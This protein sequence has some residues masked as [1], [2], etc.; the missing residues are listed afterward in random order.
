MSDLSRK[1]T[2]VR[3]TRRELTPLVAVA[4]QGPGKGPR[5]ELQSGSLTIGS[6]KDC[7]LVLDDATVSRRHAVVELWPGEVVVK[8]LGSR[9]GTRY[10]G[11]RITS[12]R[13]PAG[14]SILVG[15][16][17]IVFERKGAERELSKSVQLGGLIGH[18]AAMRKTFRM[19]EK[20]APLDVTVLVLGETGAGKGAVA[21]TL[22]ELS[23][24]RERPFVVFDCASAHPNL[25]EATLFGHAKGAYTGA[26]RERRGVIEQAEGGTLLLDEVGELPLDVQPKLL[27]LLEARQYLPLGGREVCTANIRVVAA[28]NR[29]LAEQVKRGAFRLDLYHRL[30]V[31]EVRV[32]PLRERADDIA[33]LAEAMARKVAGLDVT[34]APATV[35]AFQCARWEG[36]VR[37]LR[38]AVE[39]VLSLGA[40]AGD[41]EAPAASFIAARDDAMARFERDYLRALLKL[42]KNNVSAAAR[43]AKLVRSHLYRLLERH[44]LVPKR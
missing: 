15:K 1:T 3:S 25:I 10:L 29:D 22:H 4:T 38:N 41:D 11:A 31:A 16:T 13:V 14:G 28:T 9:N 33:P 19:I 30:A 43:S 17:T 20:V 40:D 7:D 35:A 37:E 36:N 21:Q 32:P 12:G 5:V 18:S 39:R 23:P 34:L 2:S 8:D 6:G 27:R 42:H 24:R 44:D 26:E